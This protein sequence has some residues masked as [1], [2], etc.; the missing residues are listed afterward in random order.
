MHVSAFVLSQNAHQY[1]Y[2]L[3]HFYL[4]KKKHLNVQ[5]ELWPNAVLV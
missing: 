5:I 3:R 2:F 1:C 4:K